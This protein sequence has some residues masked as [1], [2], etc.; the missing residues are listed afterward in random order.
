MHSN[1]ENPS[2]QAFGDFSAPP[3]VRLRGEGDHAHQIEADLHQI[4]KIAIDTS[5]Y[6]EAL[7]NFLDSEVSNLGNRLSEPLILSD[8][9]E[10]GKFRQICRELQNIKTLEIVGSLRLG[11][12][13]VPENIWIRDR[14]GSQCI[15]FLNMQN[16]QSM[17]ARLAN[18]TELVL[19]NPDVS[20]AIIRDGQLPDT[21]SPAAS[22]ALEDFRNA[23]PIPPCPAHFQSLT[24]DQRL[25]F[26]LM[27][28]LVNAL[29]NR[30]LE[31]PKSE[32]LD[33]FAK[34]RPENWIIRLLIRGVGFERPLFNNTKHSLVTTQV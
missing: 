20:F 2:R 9:D 8:E 19:Q 10:L 1:N 16:S 31:I 18:F 3:R 12:K 25:Q 28:S 27:Y 34:L 21:Y 22:Q 14:H 6:K 26:E 15:G 17:R 29:I 4:A 7:I 11:K 24:A 33:L 5:Q 23:R 13:K 32:A 30:D